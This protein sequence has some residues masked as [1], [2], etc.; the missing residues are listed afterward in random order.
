MRLTINKRV[1]VCKLEH[2]A[3]NCRVF[4]DYLL[5]GAIVYCRD[6]CILYLITEDAIVKYIAV[7]DI[8]KIAGMLRVSEVKRYLFSN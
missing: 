8:N 3:E 4:I 5:D 6:C 2:S 7:L 1:E